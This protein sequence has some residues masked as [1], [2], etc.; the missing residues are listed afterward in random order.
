[1]LS[2][3]AH[4]GRLQAAST[5]EDMAD[6]RKRETRWF[7]RFSFQKSSRIERNRL[8]GGPPAMAIGPA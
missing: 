6:S 4:A 7:I 2:V 3:T 1:M 8:G 5:A